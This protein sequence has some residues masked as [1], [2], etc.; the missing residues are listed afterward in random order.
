M[1]DDELRAL[2]KAEVH[3]HLEGCFEVETLVALAASAGE[4]LPREPRRL[5][6]FTTFDGFLEF[7][8]WSCGLVRTADAVAA[9]AYAYAQRASDSGVVGAD[10]I[11]NPTHWHTWHDDLDGFVGALDAGL[12]EAEQDGLA[13]VGLSLSIMRRQSA[14]EAAELV[15]WMIDAHHPRV[16]ALSVD[17]NEQLSGPTGRR[18]HAAFER[19]GEAGFGRTVHA[20]E[21][22]GPSGVIDAL[23]L[24]GA[25][26]IDHGV[27]AIESS[28][29]VDEL[30][31][32][33]VPL[34]VCPSSNIVLGLFP[35]IEHHPIEELRRQGVTVTVNTDDPA[36]VGTDL[37]AEYRRCIDAFDWS[38]DVVE[39]LAAASLAACFQLARVNS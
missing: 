5:F 32:R 12:R 38:D 27:R 36:F 25:D 30:V 28:E 10:L 37:V 2:P 11:V 26:R 9:A 21:S 15:D 1:D 24:L 29:V 18:F 13:T 22:S 20:G 6:E 31:G 19:A 23:H 16:V 4:A 35:D 3:V 39:S 33:G 34:G 7:L 8:S 17:G 14:T